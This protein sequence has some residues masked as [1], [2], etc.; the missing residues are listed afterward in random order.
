MLDDESTGDPDF[1]GSSVQ[2]SDHGYAI[3]RFLLDTESILDDDLPEAAVPRHLES[4]PDERPRSVAPTPRL[5]QP[6]EIV[7]PRQDLTTEAKDIVLDIPI[8]ENGSRG[9]K[10]SQVDTKSPNASESAHLAKISKP[11]RKS[12]NRM[13]VWNKAAVSASNEKVFGMSLRDSYVTHGDL[14]PAF[15]CRCIETLDLHGL[16]VNMIYSLTGNVGILE[17]IKSVF[18]QGEFQQ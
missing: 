18:D 13:Y 11:D 16:E 4:S 6:R 1:E 15:V 14:V 8:A 5:E 12:T 2:G 9:A 17:G 3:R 7:S 10:K